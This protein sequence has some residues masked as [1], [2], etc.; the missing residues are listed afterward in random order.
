V[1]SVAKSSGRHVWK[2]G[3]R[4]KTVY[5]VTYGGGH[6]ALVDL[7]CRELERRGN[8]RL[9][10]L[11]LTTAYREIVDRYPVGTVRRM[12]DY[13]ELFDAELDDVL[14]HGQRLAAGNHDPTGRIP[15]IESIAYLGMSYA[16]L[17]AAHGEAEAA[18]LYAEQGRQAF[19]PIRT[20]KR[21]LQHERAD[22]VF[23]T[24]SP[25][26]EE[27]A[28]R[29]GNE[30]EIPTVEVLDLFGELYPLPAARHVVTSD[31]DSIDTL[32]RLGVADCQ[33][34]DYG[35]PCFEETAQ[36]VALVDVVDTRRRAGIDPARPV[37]LVATGG[38]CLHRPDYTIERV[39]PYE[40]FLGP[41]FSAVEEVRRETG[42]Q[43][44]LRRHPNEPLEL[45]SSWFERY[46]E[47]RHANPIL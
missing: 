15:R 24:T 34:Y 2:P 40:E 47:I 41:L 3:G 10:I 22:V 5:S 16:D 17:A 11:A 28:L 33:Y 42:A 45:F 1:H 38:P 32:R 9:R 37:L 35:Q 4:V 14:R 36:Q 43:V 13:L 30:L 21:I 23:S 12:A 46:P 26:C 25:R 19:L 6:V 20:L 31:Q 27:A 18:R 29:A 44:L 39:L 8:V 7:V